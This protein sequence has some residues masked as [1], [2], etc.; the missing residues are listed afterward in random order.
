MT[1]PQTSP[2]YL[3]T[4]GLFVYNIYTLPIFNYIY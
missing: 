4:W 3:S 1:P 2:M